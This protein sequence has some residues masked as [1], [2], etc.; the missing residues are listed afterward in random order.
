[1]WFYFSLKSYLG[2]VISFPNLEYTGQEEDLG[3]RTSRVF[4]P[5]IPSPSFFMRS[6]SR[7]FT[8]WGKMVMLQSSEKKM[9]QKTPL[10]GPG[11]GLYKGQ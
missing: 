10:G 7:Y 6:D 3:Q 2:L 4:R 11:V 8:A 9:S 1:M 5:N